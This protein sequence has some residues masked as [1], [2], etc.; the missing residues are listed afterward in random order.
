MRR[1][2]RL[3]ALPLVDLVAEAEVAIGLDI[4]VLARPEHTASTARVH[5]DAFADV[6]SRYARSS[7][8]PTLAGFL[9]WLEAA[10]E[11][12]R[13]LD[14]GHTESDAD[15]VQVLTVHAAKGLEW[16]VVAVPSLVEGVFPAHSATAVS[17]VTGSEPVEYAC[18]G[19]PKDKGWLIGLDALPYDLRGD[20]GG[21]PHLD[22]R[23]APHRKA[24]SAA[25]EAFVLE[26]GRHAVAEERRLAYVALTRARSAMLLSC[27]VWGIAKKTLAV[28]S[29]FLSEVC[30]ARPDAVRR[31]VWSPVPPPVVDDAGKATVPTNPHLADLVSATWPHDPMGER[32][33]ALGGIPERLS[34]LT[35]RGAHVGQRAIR[36]RRTFDSCWPSA[37]RD[38]A[39]ASR[40]STCR[41]ICPR[42]RSWP[43]PETPRPLPWHCAGRCRHLP[44][45][46]PV[47]GPPS[48]RG[49]RS[50]TRVPRSSTSSTC[51]A[52]PTRAPQP[53]ATS[54]R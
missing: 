30:E 47:R 52:V 2:R 41:A 48:M 23:G 51:R 9:A 20:H 17:V 8:R 12:E 46:R 21:L 5:L 25:I 31:T 14:A 54:S 29:R 24:L 10:R 50:T 34:A 49:W 19:V 35:S 42:R 3:T 43:S 33:A 37:R 6:A 39:P 44:R 45:R 4:E 18:S 32:R 1:L 22:W 11:Q 38:V 15:A 40:S 26:G 13:G 53:T 36:G 7:D 16:D 27:H 28:P